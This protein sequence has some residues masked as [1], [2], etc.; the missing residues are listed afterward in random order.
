MTDWQIYRGTGE[1]HDGID[2]LPPAP[3]WREFDG[4]PILDRRGAARS[5]RAGW[6]I[7]D[8]Q[9]H[10]AAIPTRSTWS[11]RRCCSAARCW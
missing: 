10:T 1:P 9:A 8:G 2:R 3:P 5:C 6:A 4:E 7:R 11:T